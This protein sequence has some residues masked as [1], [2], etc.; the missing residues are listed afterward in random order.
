[1]GFTLQ[2]KGETTVYQ[3]EVRCHVNE[4]DFNFTQN[5]TAVQPGT[6]GSLANNIT[7]SDFRPYATAIGLYNEY[8][9]LLVVGKLATPVPVPHNTDMTFVVK[10]DS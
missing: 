6:S 1:M 9:E 7:G 2:L 5:P 8:G 4:N 10:W 3:N